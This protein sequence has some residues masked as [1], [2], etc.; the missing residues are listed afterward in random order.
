MDRVIAVTPAGRRGYLE[1]LSHYVLADPSIQQ[2]HLWD[3][4]RAE[5]DRIYINTLAAKHDKVKVITIPSADGTNRSV[6]RFYRFCKDPDTFYIKMDDDLVYIPQELGRTLLCKART[7][8]QHNLWW[9]PLVVNNAICAWLLKYFS[10]MTVVADLTAQA[11]CEI[12]WRSSRF[13]EQLHAAFLQA[14]TTDRVSLFCVPDQDVALARFSINCIGFFGSD[15]LAAGPD[16]CPNEVDDEEWLSAVL[17]ARLKR[18]GRV[19]GDITVAHFGFFTQENDLLKTSVLDEYYKIAG[20]RLTHRPVRK[21]T[22][23]GRIKSVLL[24]RLL[25]SRTPYVVTS[26]KRFPEAGK[27]PRSTDASECQTDPVCS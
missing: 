11:G 19:V 15:V 4:C 7:T 14:L 8:R 5:S 3:N 22:L 6:N 24:N 17:P 25:G 10:E 23:K 18:P 20:L 13:A 2:W 12:G 1:L 21:E 27:A 9:S 16:F 26:P